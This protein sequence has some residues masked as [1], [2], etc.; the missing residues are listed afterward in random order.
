[1][2]EHVEYAATLHGIGVRR[3]DRREVK[4][5]A[6][7]AGD[8]APIEGA[9]VADQGA[10]VAIAEREA[11]HQVAQFATVRIDAVADRAG[12]RRLGVRLA[13]EPRARNVRQLQVLGARG[14]R[15]A[16]VEQEPAGDRRNDDAR[17]LGAEPAALVAVDA[18]GLVAGHR[19]G[20]HS[21]GD[22][23]RA[24][25]KH[26]AQVQRLAG[27]GW[28]R[29]R[30]VGAGPGGAGGTGAAEAEDQRGERKQPHGAHAVTSRGLGPGPGCPDR[31][32]Y[33]SCHHGESARP[34]AGRRGRP[35]SG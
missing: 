12:E 23:R 10:H 9:Q 3:D 18:G 17:L 34:A 26:A 2:L 21:A 15:S 1:M 11:G 19:L 24:R 25:R 29:L 14:A 16:R 6:R 32:E 27:G 31:R 22:Q 5:G 8:L 35:V 33:G 7:H 30:R 20:I 13:L 4:F 28:R